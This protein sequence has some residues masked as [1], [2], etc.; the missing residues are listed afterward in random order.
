LVVNKIDAADELALAHLRRALPD[1]V[2]VSAHTGAGL[3]RLQ[4]R[5]SELIAPRDTV[6]DV[7]IPYGR[8]DLV[9]RVHADGRID[10][11]EHMEAGTR[12]KARVPIALAA[13]LTD[14][15]TY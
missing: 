8:G 12:I 4:A 13:V 5:M 6:V 3:D 11:I 10:A 2:F 9:N 1:A 14:F 7:T 15:A